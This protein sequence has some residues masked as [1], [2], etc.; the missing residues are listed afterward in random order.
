MITTLASTSSGTIST[1]TFSAALLYARSSQAADTGTLTASGLDESSAAESEAFVLLGKREVVGTDQFTKLSAANVSAA[2]T[3]DVRVY[4][5][6]TAASG[7]IIVSAQPTTGNTVTLGLTGFTQAYTFRARAQSTIVCNATAGLT[8]SD[9]FDIVI[10]GVT[11]RFWYDLNAAGTAPDLTGVTGR[12]IDIVTGDTAD[13]VATATEAIIEAVTN[14]NSSVSTSTITID[15]AILGT[16]TVTDGPGDALGTITAVQAGTTDAA[17]QVAIGATAAETAE[18]LRD[19]INDSVGTEGTDYGT[20]TAVN[21][22]LSATVDGVIVT[23]T[24]RIPCLRQLG[25]SFTKSGANLSVSAPAGGA[26]GTLLATISAAQTGV[27]TAISLDDEGLTLGLL[28]PLVNWTSDAVRVAGNRFSIHLGSSN[29]TTAMVASYEFANQ[30]TPTVWRAGVTSVTSLDANS[31]IITPTEVV[32]N[33]RV[34]INNTNTA[35]AS[36]NAKVC[37]G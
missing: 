36:V 5:P 22:Y 11:N 7:L 12:E 35:A 1:D 15:Y 16:M 17:Y 4:G 23:L 14:L 21:P 10:G 2:Q 27:Y 13:Q 31:Q 29:V 20:S 18:N 28:P 24:D 33:V 26:D 19:A 30:S 6:G 8:Q 34:K 25:W 37:S 3:G 9:Y 32:E